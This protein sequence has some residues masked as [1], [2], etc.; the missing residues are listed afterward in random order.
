[1]AVQQVTVAGRASTLSG[2]SAVR[3]VRSGGTEFAY[4]VTPLGSLGMLTGTGPR[5]IPQQL[6]AA[7]LGRVFPRHAGACSTEMR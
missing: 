5:P 1:M 6:H 7:V 3:M 2:D 4:V